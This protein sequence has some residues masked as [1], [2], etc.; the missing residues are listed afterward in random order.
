M[1]QPYVKYGVGSEAS[2]VYTYPRVREKLGCFYIVVTGMQPGCGSE[3]ARYCN[4]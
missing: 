2:C 1:E 4:L 3:S